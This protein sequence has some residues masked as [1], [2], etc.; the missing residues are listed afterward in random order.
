MDV[1]LS[2]DVT[3]DI[4]QVLAK[5]RHKSPDEVVANAVRYYLDELRRSEEHVE[6]LGRIGDLLDREGLYDRTHRPS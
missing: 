6:A 5:G 2:V 4:E 3:K 1:T